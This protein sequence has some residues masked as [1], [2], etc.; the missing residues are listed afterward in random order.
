ML[1]VGAGTDTF[2]DFQKGQ[3]LIGLSGGLRFNQLTVTPG[4]FITTIEVASNG[5]VLASITGIPSSP[6]TASDFIAI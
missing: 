5:E 2:I 4:D 1:G 3:D 6:L